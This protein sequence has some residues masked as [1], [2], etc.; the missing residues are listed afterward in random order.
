ME[1]D[2][3]E[4]SEL[5]IPKY[6]P[7]FSCIYN[8]FGDYSGV[9]FK[10]ILDGE[11]KLLQRRDDMFILYSLED[12]NLVGYEMFTIDEEYQVNSAGFDDFEMHTI[13]GD[14]VVQDR[15]STNLESLIFIK[16]GDGRDVDGYDGR[17]GYIQYNQ[18]KD[19]RLMLI[20]QQM[21]NSMGKVYSFHVNKEPFQI[22]IEKGLSAKQKGSLLPVRQ[23]SYIR[24]SFDYRDNN[25]FYNLAAIK[26]YG[27]VE[28]MEKGAYALQKENKIVRYYKML[29]RRENGYAITGFP[30]CKQ[31]SFE[32]FDEM[33]KQYG[34]KKKIPDHLIAIHNGEYRDLNYYQEIATFMKNVEM[35]PPEEVIKLNL[36]FG[37]NGKNGTNS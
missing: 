13:N 20:F 18:E 34:F 12:I 4:I 29:G 37:E 22:L 3:K 2:I 15:N 6:A 7:I 16:F 30:F 23:T 8:L 25:F 21:Y 28:F 14:R 19:V 9:Y 35:A 1:I 36:K 24:E 32:E 31:Y 27:L 17:V 10:L 33:F 11:E 5:E 26:D